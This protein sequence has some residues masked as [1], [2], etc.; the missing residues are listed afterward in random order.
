MRNATC[1]LLVVLFGSWS[2][3][4]GQSA[5]KFT[6]PLIVA[7]FQRLN[8]TAGIAMTTIYTPKNWG[9]FRISLIMVL[10]VSN[11][12]QGSS[13]NG[14]IRYTNGGGDVS[15]PSLSIP[16]D[17]RGSQDAETPIRAKAGSPITFEVTPSGDT[18]NSTYNVF[19]VV[20]QLM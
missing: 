10:T 1:C 5:P 11:G 12:N 7:T 18:Q 16:T 9:T 8:Q 13:W 3:T 4:L 6:T 17:G 15:A 14:V 2:S 19:V 20:E